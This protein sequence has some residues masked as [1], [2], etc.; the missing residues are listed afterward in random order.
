MTTSCRNKTIR[1]LNDIVDFN[2]LRIKVSVERCGLHFK[3]QRISKVLSVK[4][5]SIFVKECKS[6]NQNDVS[7]KTSFMD[8]N[9]RHETI[10]CHSHVL[11]IH[12][13]VKPSEI[14]LHT[15]K[16]VQLDGGTVTSRH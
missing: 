11:T 10:P 9:Q 6:P 15:H 3:L 1:T 12:F 4:I 2:V 13:L 14:H 8:I 7:H 16:S 5:T